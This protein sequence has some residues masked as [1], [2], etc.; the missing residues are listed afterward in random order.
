MNKLLVEMLELAEARDPELTYRE[1]Y[2]S[3]KTKDKLER[4][5]V[6]LNG[7]KSG[8]YTKM[9]GRYLRMKDAIELI[10]KKMEDLNAGLKDSMVEEFFDAT[11]Q[12]LTRVAETAQFSLLLSK[13]ED[14][15][16]KQI[17]DKDAIIKA[18]EALVAEELQPKIEEIKKQFT[19]LEKQ[20][21]APA[22]LRI[23]KKKPEKV[24]K[25]EEGVIGDKW[26]KFKSLLKR[27]TDSLK[28]WNK[29]YDNKL[30]ALKLKAKG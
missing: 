7:H 2:K 6:E 26:E 13:Q 24:D 15:P 16:D 27:F 25:L 23:S 12:A 29:D 28:S 5:I 30:K 9:A 3:K 11:D 10:K 19:K 8:K 14:R 18:L 21:P 17:V 1:E 4:I 20:D 22:A